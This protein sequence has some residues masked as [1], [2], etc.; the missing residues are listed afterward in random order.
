MMPANIQVKVKVCGM[1]NLDDVLSAVDAGAD[2][3]GFIF[4]KKSPRSVN[5]KIVS[6][7]VSK[8][9]PFVDAVGV[10][11]NETADKINKIADRCKLDKVQLH[12]DESPAFCR[13]IKRKVI[14]AIRIKDLQ[15]VK[16]LSGYS[17]S[18][19]LLDTFSEDN[20]GGTGKIFDWNLAHPAKKFGPIILAGGLNPEN[21]KK[22]IQIAR[23]YGVDACSGLESHPGVKDHKKMRTFIKNVK[24]GRKI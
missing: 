2:A 23:P 19:F 4:Y 13:K 12:G 18:G 5:M 21:V 6:E 8:L 24:F 9:P 10:F 7:I 1:T 20:Y 3:L 17:V 22:V 11:V 16:Q 15:S 14:K